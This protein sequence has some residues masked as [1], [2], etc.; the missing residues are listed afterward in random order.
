MEG[1]DGTRAG[2]LVSRLID[3]IGATDTTGVVP[4][5]QRWSEIVGDDIAAH[6]RVLDIRNGALIVGIDHPAWGQRLHLRK[7]AILKTIAHRFPE[8]GIRYLHFSVVD[9]IV[10]ASNVTAQADN[11]SDTAASRRATGSTGAAPDTTAP[12]TPPAS[13]DEEFQKHLAA[14]RQALEDRE[15]D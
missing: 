4:F 8:L 7:D 12:E 2:D 13:A 11:D 1:S 3:M 5:V 6:S 15:A 14:L 9:D 10:S